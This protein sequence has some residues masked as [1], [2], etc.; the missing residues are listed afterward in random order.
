M[1]RAEGVAP[2]LRRT[3]RPTLRL[4]RQVRGFRSARAVAFSPSP[5]CALVGEAS[6]GKSNLLAAIRAVLDPA[7]APL[8]PG[9]AARGGDGKISIRVRLADGGEAALT[10][11]AEDHALD[12][13][14][15]PVLFLTAAARAGALLASGEPESAAAAR[16]LEIFRRALAKGG[17]SSAAPALAAVKVSRPAARSASTGSCS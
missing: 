13:P 12:R 8:A 16:A 10:G 15:R 17:P 14:L 6:A 4:A 7:S 1:A 2:C 9:D 11:T 5:L 3:G